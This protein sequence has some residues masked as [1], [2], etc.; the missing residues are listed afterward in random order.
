MR[1]RELLRLLRNPQ[2]VLQPVNLLVKFLEN[3]HMNY[4]AAVVTAVSTVLRQAAQ[5]VWDGLMR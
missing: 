3:R 1:L 5:D 2:V 4:D